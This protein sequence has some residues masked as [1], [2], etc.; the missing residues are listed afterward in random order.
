MTPK[1]TFSTLSFVALAYFAQATVIHTKDN[2]LEATLSSWGPAF[3]I[4]FELFFKKKSFRGIDDDCVNVLSFAD[5]PEAKVCKQ[6]ASS[7]KRDNG[8]NAAYN[9]DLVIAAALDSGRQ[10]WRTKLEENTWYDVHIWQTM[11][12]GSYVFQA[13]VN[14]KNREEELVTIVSVENNDPRRY[15]D[16]EVYSALSNDDQQAADAMIKNLQFE[17]KQ[18]MCLV[19]HPV[20]PLPLCPRLYCPRV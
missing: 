1:L 7:R 4:K 12:N 11:V 18:G 6:E 17:D 16:V 13:T 5:I 3:D 9:Y 20:S 8:N 2:Q 14:R 15:T 19:C 10:S